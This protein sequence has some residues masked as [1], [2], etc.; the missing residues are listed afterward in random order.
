MIN[1]ILKDI[2]GTKHQKMQIINTVRIHYIPTRIAERK[3]KD[4][5]LTRMQSK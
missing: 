3:I 4:Q 2:I 5:V 1:N